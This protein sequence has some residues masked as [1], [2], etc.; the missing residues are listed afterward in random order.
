MSSTMTKM[1]IIVSRGFVGHIYVGFMITL[2]KSLPHK[3]HFIYL[4]VK[5]FYLLTFF[6]L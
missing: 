6:L 2:H 5:K 3:F 4:F 1:M